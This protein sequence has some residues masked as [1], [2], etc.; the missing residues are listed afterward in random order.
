M[1]TIANIIYVSYIYTIANVIFFIQAAQETD[2]QKR[3]FLI[4]ILNIKNECPNDI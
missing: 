1:L 4:S 3:K 2:A